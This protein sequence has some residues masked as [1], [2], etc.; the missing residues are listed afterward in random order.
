MEV[1]AGLG[2][3]AAVVFGLVLM[4]KASFWLVFGVLLPLFWLWMLIDSIVRRNEEYPSGSANEK[5][6]WIV[7]IV[8]LPVAAAPYWF[9]VY[10]AAKRTG[11]A[12]TA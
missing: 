11:F 5:L 12:A 3:L 8:V 9:M 7:L 1:L 10:R 6:L 4:V 2:L